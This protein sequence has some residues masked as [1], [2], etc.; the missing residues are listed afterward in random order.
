VA[1]ALGLAPTH[2]ALASE[3]SAPFSD[4]GRLALAIVIA[5]AAAFRA[6]PALGIDT[7]HQ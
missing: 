2:H 3:D 5:Y 7:P 1:R 4:H 6:F